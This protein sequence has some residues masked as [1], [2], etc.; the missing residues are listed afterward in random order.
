M[1]VCLGLIGVILLQPKGAG[2]GN[3]SGSYT[4]TRRG[5]EKFM[6]NSTIILSVL[7]VVISIAN[8]LI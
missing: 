8:I 2:L 1:I 5:A 6:F 3:N 4:R 7:F